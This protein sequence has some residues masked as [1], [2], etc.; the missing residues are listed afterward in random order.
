[1]AAASTPLPAAGCVRGFIVIWAARAAGMTWW[2][3]YLGLDPGSNHFFTRL[4][5]AAMLLAPAME[6][7]GNQSGA[8]SGSEAPGASRRSMDK[9][10]A[11]GLLPP[12]PRGRSGTNGRRRWFRPR[13]AAIRWRLPIAPFARAKQHHLDGC[14]MTVRRSQFHEHFARNLAIFV[15]ARALTL[16]GRAGERQPVNTSRR[17]HPE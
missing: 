1:M 7:G 8:T 11:V 6:C 17:S 15:L 2:P 9:M 4:A 14:R 5:S 10:A 3:G 13:D 12:G 16:A